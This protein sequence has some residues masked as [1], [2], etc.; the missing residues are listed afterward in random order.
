MFSLFKIQ[1]KKKKRHTHSPTVWQTH[2]SKIPIKYK[3]ALEHAIN[4]ESILYKGYGRK[5]IF[6]LQGPLKFRCCG[7]QSG[8]TLKILSE[9]QV[10]R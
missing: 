9:G 2:S 1:K 4:W 10:C 6:P 8:P 5:I 3:P 7:L